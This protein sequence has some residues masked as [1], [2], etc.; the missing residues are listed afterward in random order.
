MTNKVNL[1]SPWVTFYREIEALFG[2]DPDIRIE[3]D[4]EHP[5]IKMY[6]EDEEK[7]N[8]LMQ[9][10]PSERTFGNVTIKLTV[11]PANTQKNNYKSLFDKAFAGNPSF[12]YS[13]ENTNPNYMHLIYIV[14]KKEVVQFFNDDLSDAHGVM[15]TLYQDIAK[16]IFKD[17]PGIFF[18]TDT[19]EKVGKPLGEWP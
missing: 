1:S 16:D 19:E 9:I 15:S 8:A 2:N 11:I 17:I 7:A 6:V 5:H 10:L 3:Y 18:C 12:A 13:H 14:F 4:E